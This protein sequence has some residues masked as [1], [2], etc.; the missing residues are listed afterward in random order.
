[1]SKNLLRRLTRSGGQRSLLQLFLFE[2]DAEGIDTVLLIVLVTIFAAALALQMERFSADAAQTLDRAQQ[3]AVQAMG[4][5]AQGETVATYGWS[6]VYRQ[7]LE[8]DSRATLAQ[9]EGDE[10]AAS[11]Y[12]AVRDRA[13][14]LTPLLSSTFFDS[15]S[16]QPPN[17]RA[18][19]AESYLVPA[20]DLQERYLRSMT[21][22]GILSEKSDTLS[23]LIVLLG[24]AVALFALAPNERL[25]PSRALRVAPIVGGGL[26][27]LYVAIAAGRVL[28]EPLPAYSEEAPTLYAQGVGLTYQG[29]HALAVAAFDQAIAYEPDYAN[30]FF[31]RGNAHFALGDYPAAAADYQSARQA[32]RDDVQVLWNL[33]WTSYVLGNL[34]AAIEYSQQALTYDTTQVA[35]Y[36]NLGAAHLASGNVSAAQ[37]AYN[38]GLTIA[39]AAA[40]EQTDESGATPALWAYLEIAIGDLERLLTCLRSQLCKETPPY[41]HLID[42]AAVQTAMDEVRS[43]LKSAAVALEYTRQ[44]PPAQINGQIGT[45]EFGTSAASAPGDIA[46]FTPFGSQLP[47]VRFGLALEEESTRT[48]DDALVLASTGDEPTAVRFTYTDLANGQ[49]FVMKVYRDGVEAPWMRVVQSWTLGATGEA[50]L[51]LSSSSQFTLTDGD[52]RVEFYLD[53]R[54]LQEGR[55]QLGTE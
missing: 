22:Q 50:V 45:L 39:A 11:R 5:R 16:G 3:Y 19:E 20:T 28:L 25:L 35:L 48:T 46:N 6:D 15:T 1:M 54:L 7:W 4:T 32:G 43:T 8:W 52:Y 55:F 13:I 10:A 18:F 42:N 27:T 21:T 36:F 24:I 31:R 12:R 34:P 49:L 30:A 53:G 51:P 38:A 26:M 41:E 9:A 44:L 47:P 17:I 2:E 29:E 37:S 23:L 14:E 33:G 40:S